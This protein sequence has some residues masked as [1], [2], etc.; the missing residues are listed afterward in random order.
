M[1]ERL[2]VL[3]VRFGRRYYLRLVVPVV[4]LV[5]LGECAERIVDFVVKGGV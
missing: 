4:V 3:V 1:K 5:L 2:F